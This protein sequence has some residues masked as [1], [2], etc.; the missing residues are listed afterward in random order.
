MPVD[1][2][3]P[4]PPNL[5]GFSVCDSGYNHLNWFYSDN[6]CASDV[7]GYTLYYSPTIDLP[8]VP[9]ATFSDPTDTAYNHFPETSLSGCYFVTAIDSF[10]NE[11]QPSVRVCLDECSNYVLPNVFSPNGDGINDIYQPLRTSY[12]ERVDMRIYNRWGIEVFQTEDPDINWDGK[13]SNTDQLVSP[14]VYYYICEVYEFRLSGLE[15]DMLSGFIYV[16]SGDENEVFI[17]TK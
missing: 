14:G 1:T 4:C 2:I 9:V 3:A 15:V 16:F 17:E 6:S 8:P 11:S 12:I 5:N 10:D 13:I 7:V